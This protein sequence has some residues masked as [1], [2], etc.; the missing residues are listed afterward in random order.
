MVKPI[1][2]S[3]TAI[4]PMAPEAIAEQVLNVE[5]WS[6]FQS[7]LF[8]PGIRSARYEVR[9]PTIVGS[10]IRVENTD[11]SRHVEEIVAWHP[12]R[13]LQM[14]LGEFSAPLDHLAER[15]EET[16]EF[17]PDGPRTRVVR[18]FELHARSYFT[19][20]M[21]W[22]I[23]WLLRAAVDRQLRSMRDGGSG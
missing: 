3:C 10:R 17:H 20:P 13:G 22:M 2:F 18:R 19:R 5:R 9:T 4:L 16:W 11:G 6:E 8:M 23:S 1:T 14:R 12:G 7:F 21:I 15:F